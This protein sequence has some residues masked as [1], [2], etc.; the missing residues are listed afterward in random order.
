VTEQPYLPERRPIASRES[1]LFKRIASW[2]VQRH[3]TANSISLA[4]MFAGLAAGALFFVNGWLP[5]FRPE[6]LPLWERLSF[7]GAAL[8]IQLRLLCNMLDGMVAVESGK[9]SPV[10]ELYNEVPDRVSD[11]AIFIGAGYAVGGI[12]ELGY[13]AACVALFVAYVRAEGKVAGAPQDFRGPMAKQQRMF[14]LTVIALYCALAPLAWQ[15]ALVWHNM[16]IVSRDKLLSP[17]SLHPVGLLAAGL[18]V[19]VV[20]GLITAVRRLDRSARAL[21]RTRS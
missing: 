3:V 18:L 2:L 21:R 13:L 11:A 7:L 10:G 16:Q 9:A 20:G 5:F 15:P 8:L 14:V 12:P 19:I 4:G 1:A 6:W 17:S